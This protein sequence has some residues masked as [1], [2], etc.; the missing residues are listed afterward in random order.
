MRKHLPLLIGILAC[1]LIAAGAYLWTSRLMDS[2]YAHRS[3]LHDTPP[4]PGEPLGTPL[5]RRVV[6]V[7]IDALREDTSL[8]REVMPFLIAFFVLGLATM[9][10]RAEIMG[11]T[12]TIQSRPRRGTEVRVVLPLTAT[13]PTNDTAPM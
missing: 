7:L 2:V 6:F 11:A 10:E 13:R 12:L 9:R 5:T 8:K 4:A 3:L 1:L